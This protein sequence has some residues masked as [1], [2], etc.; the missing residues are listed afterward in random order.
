MNSLDLSLVSYQMP[1]HVHIGENEIAVKDIY[2]CIFSRCAYTDTPLITYRVIKFVVDHAWEKFVHHFQFVKTRFQDPTSCI[3]T[4]CVIEKIIGVDSSKDMRGDSC[5]T[6][7][8]SLSLNEKCKTFAFKINN[9]LNG[10]PLG[11]S[12][13][14]SHQI[15]WLGQ[16]Q[17]DH[18]PQSVRNLIET[19]RP[20]INVI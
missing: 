10:L 9:L 7:N 17:N 13:L 20:K 8:I 18:L 6:I 2:N 5:L 14:E 3:S 16:T 11:Q 12:F 4:V 1:N 19:M 15:D